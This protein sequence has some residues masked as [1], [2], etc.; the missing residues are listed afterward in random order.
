VDYEET[1]ALVSRYTSIR[2]IMSLVLFMEW[3]IHQM[4]V[5]T[6]F[7]NGIIEEEVYIE[8][9]QGFE[10]NGKESPVCRLRKTLCGLNQALSAWYSRTDGYLQSMGFTKSEVDP[11]LYYIFVGIDLLILVLYVD[12]LFLIGAEK[13]IAW[14]K[15][16]MEA[17]F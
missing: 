17:K 10:V 1:F 12:D 14:C 13:L 15:V 3:M 7:L 16:D 8:Q 9:P 5:E 2:A 11:N 6:T 4:D